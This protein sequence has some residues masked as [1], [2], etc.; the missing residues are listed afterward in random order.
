MFSKHFPAHIVSKWRFLYDNRRLRLLSLSL[1]SLYRSAQYGL[2]RQRLFW[3]RERWR[4]QHVISRISRHMRFLH[5]VLWTDSIHTSVL[6]RTRFKM[7]KW[8]QALHLE[9]LQDVQ[10]YLKV[11]LFKSYFYALLTVS[12]SYYRTTRAGQATGQFRQFAGAE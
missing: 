7:L 1:R 9:W 5:C 2:Q 3:N 4:P 11:I 12:K 8:L 10:Q 6:F